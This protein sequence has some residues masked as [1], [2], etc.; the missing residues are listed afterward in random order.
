MKRMPRRARGLVFQ[1]HESFNNYS[2][3]YSGKYRANVKF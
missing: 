2:L 3:N 1:C